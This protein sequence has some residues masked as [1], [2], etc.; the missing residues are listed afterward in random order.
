MAAKEKVGD[1]ART[2]GWSNERTVQ[3]VERLSLTYHLALILE[4]CYCDE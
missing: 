2:D 4:L 1:I 3:V